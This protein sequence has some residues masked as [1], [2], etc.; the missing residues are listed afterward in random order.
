[1][2]GRTPRRPRAARLSLGLDGE[3]LVE[4]PL[5][6]RLAAE[7]R[8]EEGDDAFPRRLGADHPRTERQDVHVVV[9]DPLVGGVRVVAH[10]RPDA[11]DLVRRDARPDAGAADQDA[12]VG[13]TVADRVPELRREV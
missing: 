11:A 8:A 3:D 4:A 1:W 13:L 10:G 9:L 12:A 5:V 7:G 6:A 2:R